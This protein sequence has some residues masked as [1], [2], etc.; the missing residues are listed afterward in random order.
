M[1]HSWSSL[2]RF[3][4]SPLLPLFHLIITPFCSHSI[5]PGFKAHFPS[6]F[7]A[8]MNLALTSRGLINL[9]LLGLSQYLLSLHE[10]ARCRAKSA[11]L[12]V[13][14]PKFKF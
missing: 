14:G 7:I 6:L 9:L 2:G 1:C 11:G 10:R 5:Y 13:Q 3:T 12:G 8:S 4:H